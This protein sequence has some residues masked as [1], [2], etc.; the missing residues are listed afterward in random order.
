MF[1]VSLMLVLLQALPEED[2]SRA[3]LNTTCSAL[4]EVL[5]RR[6]SICLPGRGDSKNFHLEFISQ[7]QLAFTLNQSRLH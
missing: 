5:P 6:S 3:P 1:G 4:Q 2:R 7:Q